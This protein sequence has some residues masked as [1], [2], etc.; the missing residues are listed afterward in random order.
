MGWAVADLLC[1]EL[2]VVEREW[3]VG[4]VGMVQVMCVGWNGG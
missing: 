1:T 3:R 4:L 2:M